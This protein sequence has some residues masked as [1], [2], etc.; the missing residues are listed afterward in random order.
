MK[1]KFNNKYRTQSNRM[2]EW[3]YADNGFYFITCVTQNRV[4]NL[5]EI[6]ANSDA[7][8]YIQLSD[9]GKIVE[10]EFLKSFEMCKELYL[11]EYIIMSNHL[12][13]IIELRKPTD[14][15]T[16][17]NVNLA[18]NPN[19]ENKND[20]FYRKPKSISSFIGGYKSVIN[21]KIDDYIDEHNLNIPKYNRNNHFFLSNYNDRVIRDKDEYWRIKHYIKNNPKN[22]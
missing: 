22:W 21:T 13:A 9:F 5:G 1:G 19:D 18:I 14:I 16:T 3:D 2:P 12:H 10:T 20:K 8:A 17:E 11:D 15:S 4:C 7:Q 6:V